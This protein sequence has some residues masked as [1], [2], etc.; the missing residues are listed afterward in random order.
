MTMTTLKECKASAVE[1]GETLHTTSA[2]VFHQSKLYGKVAKTKTLLKK[3]HL[4]QSSPK[5]M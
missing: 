5:G 1:M 3:A 4:N 2:R